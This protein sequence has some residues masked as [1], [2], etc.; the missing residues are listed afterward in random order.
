MLDK[1]IQLRGEQLTSKEK[2]KIKKALLDLHNLEIMATNVYRCQITNR[3]PELKVNLI[4]AMKNEMGHVQDYLVKLF[5]YDFTPAWYRWVFW[6][7]G[8]VIGTGSR[9]QGKK[10][11]LKA[12]IWTESKAV[13]HYEELLEIAPWDEETFRVIDKDRQDEVQHLELWTGLL[14]AMEG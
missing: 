6:M 8:W 4:G 7:V 5:E 2:G 3:Y 9:I 12:G 14:K 10:G 1:T 13:K 11:I